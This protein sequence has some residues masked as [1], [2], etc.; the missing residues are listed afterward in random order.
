MCLL[1]W[2]YHKQTHKQTNTLYYPLHKF[3]SAGFAF[4]DI[5]PASAVVLVSTRQTRL[6][7]PWVPLSLNESADAQWK[8][9]GRTHLEI[10]VK[11]QYKRLNK[12]DRQNIFTKTFFDFM[13]NAHSNRK[14]PLISN[15]V[16]WMQQIVSPNVN[17]SWQKKRKDV[18]PTSLRLKFCWLVKNIRS[19][20]FL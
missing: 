13:T 4:L 17:S 5:I 8:G 16:Y 14:I 20:F 2:R 19:Y 11:A 10:K 1:E 12:Y 18:R 9:A 6:V 7:P 3:I 15:V